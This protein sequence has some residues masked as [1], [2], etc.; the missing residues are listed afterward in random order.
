MKCKKHTT[1]VNTPKNGSNGKVK[2]PWPTKDAMEQIYELKLWGGDN[3]DFYSG[4]GSHDPN[5]V[6]PYIEAV[7]RF[8]R[9]F[10]TPLVVCDLGCGDFNV[11]RELVGHTQSYLAVDIVED[12][13]DRNKRTFKED[14]L[15]FHCLDIAAEKLPAANCA[16]LRHVLQHLSNSEI[17]CI[18]KKL[19]QFKYVILTEHLP[20]GDFK[21]NKNIISGQGIRLKKESGT[22]LLSPPFNLNIREEKQLLCIPSNQ[23]P[24][25]IKTTL[26]TMH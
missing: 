16:I 10:E 21:P 22:D 12:L 15:E 7:T 8:L 18:V 4:E 23:A 17:H 3:S 24:G 19:K 11:G 20:E 1:K 6:E 5:Y 14:N 2:K 25:I 26:Y 13:I 9:S